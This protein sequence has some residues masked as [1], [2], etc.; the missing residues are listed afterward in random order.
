MSPPDE[1]LVNPTT[2]KC[3]EFFLLNLAFKMSERI[4]IASLDKLGATNK[5]NH[6]YIVG[7]LVFLQKS[8]FKI[9]GNY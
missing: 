3:V 7:K 8:Y 2:V 6:I 9:K 5:Q 1:E 4:A